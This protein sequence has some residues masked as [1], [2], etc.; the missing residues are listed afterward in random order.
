[1]NMQSGRAYTTWAFCLPV[2][3][4]VLSGC[5]TESWKRT[6]YETAQNI[7][8]QQCRKQLTPECGQRESYE[9]Y[10]HKKEEA[11]ATE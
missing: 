9:E 3:L 2:V 5:N 11:L 7:K 6:A 4:I 1:M 8:Q 10:Q